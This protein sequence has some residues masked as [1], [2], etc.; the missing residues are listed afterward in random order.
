[1]GALD[2]VGMPDDAPFREAVR[3]HLEFGSQVAMQNSNATNED[4]LHPLGQVPRW[5]WDGDNEDG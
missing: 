5:T 2:E 1:M 4:E 3:S